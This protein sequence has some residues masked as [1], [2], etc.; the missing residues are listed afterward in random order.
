MTELQVMGKA[1]KEAEKT[2][3]LC[4]T[5]LKNEALLAIA[6]KLEESTGGL[7]DANRLDLDEAK[8]N[9]MSAALLDRLTLTAER[10]RG[11]AS[12][13]REIAALPDPVGEI[14]STDVRP[15]GLRIIQKRVPLG[16]VGMIF[17]ARPNVIFDATALSLK[18]FLYMTT[19]EQR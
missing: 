17:E 16:V 4:G 7:L 5:E 18:I 3:A 8:K 12:G 9:G 6:S 11:I 13:I 19:Q 15:N 1:A 10:I 14:L 2:L